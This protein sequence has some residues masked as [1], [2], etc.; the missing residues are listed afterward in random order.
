[1]VRYSYL[2]RFIE[3]EKGKTTPFF[4]EKTYLVGPEKAQIRIDN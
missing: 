4:Y 2:P 3:N 1:M